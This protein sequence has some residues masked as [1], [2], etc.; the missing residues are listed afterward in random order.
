MTSQN[1]RTNV[2]LKVAIAHTGRKQRALAMQ[3]GIPEGRLS[4]FVQGRA[5]P[6]RA[7]IKKLARVLG[8]TVGEVERLFPSSGA[9]A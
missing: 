1:F 3:A 7:E 4:Y 8:K 2:D 9:E 6:E 5:L